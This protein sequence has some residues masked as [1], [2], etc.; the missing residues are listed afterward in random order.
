MKTAR[1]DYNLWVRG[2][3]AINVRCEFR[4]RDSIPSVWQITDADLGQVG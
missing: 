2:L 3:I 1:A 4:D